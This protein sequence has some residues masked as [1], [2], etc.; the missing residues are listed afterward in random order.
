[1][2]KYLAELRPHPVIWGVWLA[3]R[4]PGTWRGG[5]GQ[6]QGAGLISPP[7]QKAQTWPVEPW[8]SHHPRCVVTPSLVSLVCLAL[9]PHLRWRHWV[10]GEHSS[11][12][13]GCVFWS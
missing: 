13:A 10:R 1:M 3:A 2:L 8:G 11:R 5:R 9:Q 4:Q 6:V 12:L 7:Y